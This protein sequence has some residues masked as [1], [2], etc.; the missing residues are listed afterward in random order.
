MRHLGRHK[1][2]LNSEFAMVAKEIMR[3]LGRRTTS[4]VKSPVNL[5]S[6]HQSD[7]KVVNC[8]SVDGSIDSTNQW[9]TKRLACKHRQ[10]TRTIATTKPVGAWKISKSRWENSE[11]GKVETE[12]TTKL[13]TNMCDGDTCN[14]DL[15]IWGNGTGNGSGA[16]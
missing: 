4:T 3:H 8:K 6:N 9:L 16:M 15:A 2:L 11:C 12:T 1:M 13:D 5:R 7:T 10:C 14:V